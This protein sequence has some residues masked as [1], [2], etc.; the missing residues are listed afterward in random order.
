MRF[1]LNGFLIK[2]TFSII[3]VSLTK[4]SQTKFCLIICYVGYF[5]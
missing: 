3:V 5:L 2:A 1:S 4:Q